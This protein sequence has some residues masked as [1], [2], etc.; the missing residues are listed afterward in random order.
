ME[1]RQLQYFLAV[2]E[3]GSFTKAAQRLSV[4]QPGV[5]AQIKQL[6]EELGEVLLQRADRLVSLTAAGEVFLPFARAAV[7]A[8]DDGRAAIQQ[9]TGL[10]GGRVVIGTVYSCGFP[11]VPSVLA[12]FRQAFP[13]VEISL[14]EGNSDRLIVALQKGELDLALVGLAGVAPSGI[15]TQ[16]LVDEPIV[17]AVVHGH[18]LASGASISLETLCEQTIIAMPRGTGVRACFDL[19]CKAAKLDPHVAFEVSNLGVVAQLACAGLGVALLPES[20]AAPLKDDLHALSVIPPLR[21]RLEL[22]WRADG[23]QSPA[24][25]ELVA[26]ARKKF[27]ELARPQK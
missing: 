19:G 4:T 2:V 25:R 12:E 7:S 21:S 5:S 18:P 20:V 16:V 10:L 24:A 9:L 3:L 17:A 8:A 6:E 27:A 23:V 11:G 13:E 22:A 26:R 15:E 1:L 14:T